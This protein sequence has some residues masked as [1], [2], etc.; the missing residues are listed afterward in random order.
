MFPFVLYNRPEKPER[1]DHMKGNTCCFTGHRKL[2]KEAEGSIRAAIRET[3][4]A[5]MEKG[6]DTFL[7]GGAVGF[8]M[9]A[10]EILLELRTE[11]KQFRLIS[12]L[13]F[14]EWRAKWPEA[15]IERED[16]ILEASDEILISSRG[17]SRHS[18]L[19]RDRMMLDRSEVC[20]AYCKQIKG[21]TA[22]TVRYAVRQGLEIINLA[23]WDIGRLK[24]KAERPLL[25]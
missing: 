8:D 4:L 11:G 13:P 9:L 5:Q 15:E 7:V 2:R 19:D 16:R 21:G 3:V 23:E 6:A 18:Y 25:F 1:T 20:I 22:Y 17:Y 24:E 12:A 14:L 10:S